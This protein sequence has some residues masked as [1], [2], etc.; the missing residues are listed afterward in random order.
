VRRH[1]LIDAS[2]L[3]PFALKSHGPAAKAKTAVNKLLILR[4][5]GK[6]WLYT[7]NFC[8][9]ECSKAFAGIVFSEQKDFDRAQE[10][11]LRL[12]DFLLDT[13]SSRKR[14]LIQSYPL[15]RRHLVNVE[16][17]FKV[18]YAMRHHLSSERLSGLDALVISMGR[19]LGKIYGREKVSI[20]TQD[21]V[22]ARVCN[23]NRPELPKAI[24]VSKDPI[25]DG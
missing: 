12:V 21:A 20:V 1:Y 19:D 18:E 23:H 11:Y 2:A 24:D 8:M 16:D 25:P 13:V 10:E 22:M 7:P 6:A 4:G 3:V 17:I 5:E 15:R 14:R 9:A